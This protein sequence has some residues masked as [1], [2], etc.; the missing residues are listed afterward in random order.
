MRTNSN[1]EFV[2][3]S[4]KAVENNLYISQQLLWVI[5]SYL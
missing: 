5:A 1:L 2:H 3:I 4:K